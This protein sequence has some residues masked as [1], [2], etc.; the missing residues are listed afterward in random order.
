MGI[1][2]SV[3][4]L[5]AALA[6]LLAACGA[7]VPGEPP[8]VPVRVQQAAA[9][10]KP[11]FTEYIAEIR[12]GSE[13]AVYPRIGGTIIARHFRE[14]S[15]VRAG[16]VLFEIDAQEFASS[17]D[18]ARAQLAASQAQ[19][20]RANED[21]ARYEPLVAED[22]IARQVF[23]NAVATAKASAAQVRA[24]EASLANAELTLSYGKV[25]API[26]G[27][28]GKAGAS[29]GQLI[30][31]GQIELARISD[32]SSLDVYFSPSEEEVL[33]Y[34]R[35]G[36]EE[37]GNGASEI[38]LILA[39]GTELPQTG[40]IDFADRAVDPTTGSYSLRAVFPNPGSMVRPGQ[41]GR[42]RIQ[43]QTRRDAVIVPDRAV[44][45]QFGTYFVMVVGKD[46]TVEQRRVE[47]GAQASGDWI[48]EKGLEP[49]ETV[50][51]EGLAKVRPGAKVQ[52][53]PMGAE[54]PLP[55]A[56]DAGQAAAKK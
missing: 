23:D 38:R 40:A 54:I 25:R 2:G 14:G 34:A 27:R 36:E 35:I 44:T 11:L 50:I 12:A 32:A 13:V 21:V 39:D 18:A 41:F 31:P 17:R 33:R 55:G 6:L 15:M 20:A 24:A 49:G 28:I 26:S 5:G 45:E 43:I 19:A 1:S 3:R 47:V 52:P 4:A 53:V 48:I 51:V 16:Q 7:A 46:N 37:R 8:P 42:V 29:V 9:Q 30:S 56:G 22:A 10:D